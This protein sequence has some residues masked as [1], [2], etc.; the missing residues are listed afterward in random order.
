MITDKEEDD[1]SFLFD[2]ISF[3]LLQEFR[4]KMTKITLRIR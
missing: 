3:C 2:S 1:G 4:K